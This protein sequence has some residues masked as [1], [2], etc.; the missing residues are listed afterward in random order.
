MHRQPLPERTLRLCAKVCSVESANQVS[1][2]RCVR[3]VQQ[4][5]LANMSD[6]VTPLLMPDTARVDFTLL[7]PEGFTA[8]VFSSFQL[9][10]YQ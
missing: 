8:I 4:L 7:L 3:Q 10:L 6:S 2:D 9:R 1:V 5:S